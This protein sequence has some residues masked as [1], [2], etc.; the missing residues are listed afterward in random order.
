M[1]SVKEVMRDSLEQIRTLRRVRAAL[2]ELTRLHRFRQM[3]INCFIESDDDL[4][5]VKQQ[6]PAN[7]VCIPGHELERVG[8]GRR[9]LPHVSFAIKFVAGI[10]KFPVVAAADELIEFGFGERLFIEVAGIECQSEIEQ[11]TSC[12]AASGSSGL[13]VVDEFV[14]HVASI[15]AHDFTWRSFGPKGGL[16]DYKPRFS[17]PGDKPAQ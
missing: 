1:R 7:Q 15:C 2:L 3:A 5:T 12:F 11:E 13:L 8:T 17:L 6:R 14:G 16:Q 9:S 10:Q 4:R